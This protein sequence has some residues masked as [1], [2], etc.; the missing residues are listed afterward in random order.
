MSNKSSIASLVLLGIL[1]FPVSSIAAADNCQSFLLSNGN[2]HIPIEIEGEEYSAAI[3]T[4]NIPAAISQGLVDV[5]GLKERINPN[6]RIVSDTGRDRVFRYVTGLPVNLFGLDTNIEELAIVGDDSLYLTISLRI[7]SGLLVQINFPEKKI[8]FL[9]RDSIDLR[10]AQNIQ[11]DSSAASGTPVVFLTLND[12]FDTW[13]DFQPALS[14]GLRVDRFVASQLLLETTKSTANAESDFSLGVIDNLT[15]GP[16]E[17]GNIPIQFPKSG[18]RSNL[19]ER[20]Q[21][22]TDTAIQ[23]D[24]KSRGALGIDVLEHFIITM[25]LEL[26]RMHIFAP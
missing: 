2:M 3:T 18:V 1:V 26:E 13:L 17:L 25:D 20:Q 14:I 11:M 22:L 8:C 9:S 10:S 24:R 21:T 12:E 5:L 23:K 7:F 19:T 15:F 6:L 4:N 16:Y